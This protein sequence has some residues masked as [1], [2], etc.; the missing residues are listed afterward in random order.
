MVFLCLVPNL[1]MLNIQEYVS[2]TVHRVALSKG[3]TKQLTYILQN[4]KS[5]K[6]NRLIV[7]IFQLPVILH[8]VFFLFIVHVPILVENVDKWLQLYFRFSLDILHENTFIL[9]L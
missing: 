2:L 1:I 3:K 4:K 5:K 9:Q 7:E 8:L 6:A